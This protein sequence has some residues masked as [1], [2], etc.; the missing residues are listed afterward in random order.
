MHGRGAR[1]TVLCVSLSNLE[2]ELLELCSISPETTTSLDEEM[3][4]A[5]P[6]RHALEGV[7]RRLVDSGLMSTFRGTFS[8]VHRPRQGT[9]VDR[10]FEDDWWDVTEVGRRAIGRAR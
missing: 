5:S 9:P 2:R 8:G 4:K 7:L 3:L 1:P 6:G 10:V